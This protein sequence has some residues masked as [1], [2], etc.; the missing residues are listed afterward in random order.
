MHE[1]RKY[2]GYEIGDGGGQNNVQTRYD[3]NLVS[4]KVTG[5]FLIKVHG[6]VSYGHG[7]D[8]SFPD[9]SAS[10]HF[11]YE[12]KE[13]WEY[14][15]ID[16]ISTPISHT[17][18]SHMQSTVTYTDGIG[19]PWEGHFSRVRD[20]VSTMS[21]GVWSGHN[22]LDV[23][24]TQDDNDDYPPDHQPNYEYHS[25][26]PISTPSP[27]EIYDFL[28]IH[29]DPTWIT[30]E[31]SAAGDTSYNWE[32]PYPA[33][34]TDEEFFARALEEMP[35]YPEEYTDNLVYLYDDGWE[36]SPTLIG[37]ETEWSFDH[38]FLTLF[39]TEWTLRIRPPATCYMGMWFRTIFVP[40]DTE[41]DPVREEPEDLNPYE[42]K[43]FHGENGTCLKDTLKS[44]ED[45]ENLIE[46][47]DVF[48][49]LPTSTDGKTR[50]NLFK[51]SLLEG[52]EP[53]EE[54]P[55]TFGFPKIS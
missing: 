25:N 55:A 49:I 54:N 17:G 28:Y 31:T 30:W 47:E 19:E 36:S 7:E 53:D 13:N 50:L 8:P 15:M 32:N 14:Q 33:R 2:T 10:H 45:E 38:I 16:G 3:G 4:Q 48:E 41:E 52:Y 22:K 11:D 44:P 29:P 40:K 24:Y 6:E 23:V 26:V 9:V 21:G 1:K 42:W 12:W 34:E 46:V 43:N 37:A 27:L 5:E 35:D 51:W 39:K 20:S 18:S